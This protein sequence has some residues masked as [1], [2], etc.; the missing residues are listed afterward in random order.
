MIALPQR[1]YRLG[2]DYRDTGAVNNP[3]DQF[4]GWINL[5]G[6]GMR[7]MGGIRGLKFVN[8][9]APVLAAIVLVTDERSAGSASNPWDDLVE[10]SARANRLLGRRKV[11]CKEDRR[12][13]RAGNRGL[14]DAFNQ[15]L[16]SQTALVPP[17]LHFSKRTTGV[18]H[19]MACVSSTDSSSHGSRTMEDRFET[20]GPT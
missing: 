6:S 16:D 9:D 1:R 4:L 17:I 20:T 7:N 8:L 3:D 14:R 10:H 2:H 19:L 5:P 13:L 15:V 11:R 12:R 18:L